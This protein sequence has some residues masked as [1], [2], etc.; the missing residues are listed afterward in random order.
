MF[1][2]SGSLRFSAPHWRDKDFLRRSIRKGREWRRFRKLLL[3][4]NPQN[5]GIRQTGSGSIRWI[6]L[7]QQSV[8]YDFRKIRQFNPELTIPPMHD[9][10]ILKHRMLAP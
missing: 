6:F 9:C 1:R 7:I 10:A 8:M 3:L 2:R 4:L 5:N